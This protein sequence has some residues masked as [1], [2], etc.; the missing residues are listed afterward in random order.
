MRKLFFPDSILVIGVSSGSRNMGRNIVDNLLR[1]SYG[2]RIY[3]VGRRSGFY[4]GHPIHTEIDSLPEGIDLA[5][6][7]TPAEVIVDTLRACARKGIRH[8]IIESGGFSELTGKNDARD[9]ALLAVAREH[10]IRFVGP[11]G[12]GA[13]CRA[14]GLVSPFMPMDDLP[15]Q[16]DISLL[17]QSGGVGVTYIGALFVENLGM[18]RFVSLGNKL[19]LDETDYLEHIGEE[20][21]SRAVCIYLEDIRRGRAFFD[22]IRSFDGAVIV[23]KAGVT[24]AGHRAAAS[25]TAALAVD[26]RV[27]DAALRQAGAIRV[28]SMDQMIAHAKAA[29]L[30]PMTGNRLM[31]IARSGGHAVIAADVAEQSGFVLPALPEGMAALAAS[32]G[33]GHVIRTDNP[34]D[35]GDIFDFEVYNQLLIMAAKSD[36]FDGVAMIHVFA[37]ESDVRSS[38]HLLK[39][40]AQLT[41]STGKPVYICFIAMPQALVAL[42]KRTPHPL[43]DAPEAMIEAMAALRWSGARRRRNPEPLADGGDGPAPVLGDAAPGTLAAAAAWSLLERWG[44]PVAPWRLVVRRGDVASA[45]EAVGYPVVLKIDSPAIVHK[46]DVGGVEIDLPDAAAALAA[47]DRIL[48]SVAAVAPGARINGVLVQAMVPTGREIFLGGQRDP[49][50]GPLIMVGVGGVHVE[51][52]KDVSLRL[53]PISQRDVADMIAD[54]SWFRTL[55]PARGQPGADRALLEDRILAFSAMLCAEERIE[56]IDLNPF[57]LRDEGEGGT[58]VDVRIRVR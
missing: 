45:A 32:A 35:L 55:A 29:A 28:G 30:P 3:L 12:L 40:A 5:V 46:S 41:E 4:A 10:G 42:K 56:E 26:D 16:G 49:S 48:A 23:Q 51:T 39:S 37:A 44:F 47:Y 50:F 27:V 8:A 58:I 13:I 20:G 21:T 34:L 52:L 36:D 53:A 22:A 38:A 33:R 14:S 9:Q 43:F 2:G 6:I 7:L 17:A 24:A 31:I 11:N 19:C 25:H 18:D 54:V 1:F 57:L 15:R